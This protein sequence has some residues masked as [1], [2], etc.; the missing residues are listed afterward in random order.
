[1]RKTVTTKELCKKYS[2]DAR[3]IRRWVAEG[4]PVWRRGK[5]NKPSLFVPAKVEEWLAKKGKNPD[6]VIARAV[7]GDAPEPQEQTQKAAGT[8]INK[9]GIMGYL[10]RCRQQ[11]RYLHARF[12]LLS[13]GGGT[14]AEIASITRALTQKGEELRR[15]EMAALEYQ[16]QTGELC[17]YAEM[18]RTFVELASGTRERI[19]ALPTQ[20]APLLRGYLRDPDDAGQVYKLI[21]RVIRHALTA[22]PKQLPAKERSI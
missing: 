10:E 19:M 14:A 6:G 12:I 8:M 4:C 17:D 20:L 11:E 9:L 18:E 1:M 13:K 7:A 22:L 15:A 5:G 3:A 21:D 16:K 2:V